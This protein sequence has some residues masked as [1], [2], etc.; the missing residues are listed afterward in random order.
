[1][2][3]DCSQKASTSEPEKKIKHKFQGEMSKNWLFL[4]SFCSKG[5]NLLKTKQTP[6]TRITE[7][8]RMETNRK[9]GNEAF[10]GSR[11]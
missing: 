10:E 2:N 1:M 8:L 6:D 7:I 3:D 4:R 5:V 9:R 11:N